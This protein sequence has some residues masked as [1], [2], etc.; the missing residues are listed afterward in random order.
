MFDFR[1][2]DKGPFITVKL[3]QEKDCDWTDLKFSQDGCTILLTS[4]GSQI[5]LLNAFTGSP[6]QT[7]SGYQN[8]KRIPIE[9]SYSPDSQYIFSGSSDGRIH[10]WNAVTGYKVCVL[11]GDHPGPVPC[12]KFNP[13]Y[14]M[15]AT[16]CSNMAFWLPVIDDSM[17]S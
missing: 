3:P 4:N 6:V 13:K 1:S 12:V 14:M 2:Y 5:R 10:I 9:A 8:N 11:H 15:M 17:Y 16:A 7:L